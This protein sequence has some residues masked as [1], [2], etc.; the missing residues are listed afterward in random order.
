MLIFQ[1][2][3]LRIGDILSPPELL[4]TKLL[5][6]AILQM[7]GSIVCTNYLANTSGGS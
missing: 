5:L 2:L 4:L 3:Q 6:P 1:D 7:T